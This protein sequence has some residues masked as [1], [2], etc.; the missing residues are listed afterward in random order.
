MGLS[1]TDAYNQIKNLENTGK[2]TL[3]QPQETITLGTIDPAKGTFDYI[4]PT[5]QQTTVIPPMPPGK[6]NTI[7]NVTVGV[8]ATK[9]VDLLLKFNVVPKPLL[10]EARVA[11]VSGANGSTAR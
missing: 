8:V 1:V 4:V 2:L 5:I 11:V 10:T 9:A 6:T 3:P 7:I